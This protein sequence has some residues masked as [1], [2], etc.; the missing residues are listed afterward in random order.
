MISRFNLYFWVVL[1]VVVLGWRR[2]W[3]EGS[4]RKPRK[5][6]SSQGVT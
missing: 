1:D 4:K 5:E 2:A 6:T 3:G